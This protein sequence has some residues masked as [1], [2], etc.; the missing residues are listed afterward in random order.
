MAGTSARRVVSSQTPKTGSR[1]G[2][3][4]SEQLS[5]HREQVVCRDLE[6]GLAVQDTHEPRPLDGEAGVVGWPGLLYS[7]GWKGGSRAWTSRLD[8]AP[9]DLSGPHALCSRCGVQWEGGG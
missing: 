5:R 8:D 7:W 6:I 9:R 4:L 3:N 2:Q 1:K